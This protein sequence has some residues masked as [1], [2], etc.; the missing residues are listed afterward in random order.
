MPFLRAPTSAGTPG[1]GK[2][3][4]QGK[5]VFKQRI[6]KNLTLISHL[7]DALVRALRIKDTCNTAGNVYCAM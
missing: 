6:D 3:K 1:A 5:P 2:C 7:V 4:T